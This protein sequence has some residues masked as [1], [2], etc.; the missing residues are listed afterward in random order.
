MEGKTSKQRQ[1]SL[2]EQELSAL[3]S[4]K[5]WSHLGKLGKKSRDNRQEGW[6]LMR[7]QRSV[8]AEDALIIQIAEA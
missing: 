7:S 1:V 6:L 8:T 5:V 3:S 4:L 2:N